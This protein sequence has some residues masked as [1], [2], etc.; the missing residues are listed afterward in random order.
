MAEINE[1]Q[2]LIKGLIEQKH[3]DLLAKIY[4]LPLEPEKWPNVLDEFA[5]IMGAGVVGVVAYDPIYIDHKLNSASSNFTPA[6]VAEQRKL[7]SSGTGYQSAFAKMAIN[8]KRAFVNDLEMHETGDLEGYKKRPYIQWLLKNFGVYRGS[9]SCLNLHKAW[10]DIL[11][12]MF[13]KDRGPAT[14]REKNIGDF[15]LSHMAKT[16]EIGR[17]FTV[18]KNRFKGVFTSLDRLHIGVFL[19]SATG[20]IV[21]Q[22]LEAQRILDAGDGL[23][24]SRGGYLHPANENQREALK[25]AISKAAATAQAQHNRAET[26]ISLPRR[27]GADPYL[28]EISP[29][30]SNDEIESQFSGCLMFIIDPAKTDVVST[31]GMEELYKLTGAESEVCKMLAEGFE[32]NDIA[33]TRNT[34]R[35]TVRNSVK[36]ILQKT[37]TSN[38]SQLVRLALRVNLPIDPAPDGD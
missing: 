3:L 36:Q 30:R 9:A 27:S 29:L 37:G 5:A 32:T 25:D 15:F 35:E 1:S 20:S 18:L 34:T 11:F 14:E 7:F 6:L 24:T 31:K 4:D 21:H 10:S 8:P 28:V 2:A 26:L 38:R 19:L 33:D 22:N 16:V 17:S 23:L 13:P 12:C